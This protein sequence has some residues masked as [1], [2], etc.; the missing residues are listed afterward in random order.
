MLV[1]RR[2][3]GESI[4]LSGNIHVKVLEV[5]EG[6]VKIGITAPP[7]VDIVREEIIQR[8]APPQKP[9]ATKPE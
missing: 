1:I 2:K 6:R 3:E 8:Q 9:P 7:E 5:N 4:I